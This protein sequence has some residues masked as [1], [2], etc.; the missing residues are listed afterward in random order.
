LRDQGTEEAG[1]GVRCVEIE[2]VISGYM[3]Y[4]FNE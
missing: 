2:N 1:V 4:K 3:N